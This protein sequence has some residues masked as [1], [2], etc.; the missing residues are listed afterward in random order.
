LPPS[1]EALIPILYEF[2]RFHE[3]VEVSGKS[4]QHFRGET[5]RKMN[6]FAASIKNLADQGV[7]SAI[8]LYGNLIREGKGFAVNNKEAFAWFLKGAV[9]GYSPSMGNVALMLKNG[10]GVSQNTPEAIKWLR[11]CADTGDANAFFNLALIY[12]NGE[13]VPRD[14]PQAVRYWRQ[15]SERG[16]AEAMGN[17]GELLMLGLGGVVHD[18]VEALKWFQTS[19]AK[20]HRK[21][22]LGLAVFYEHGVDWRGIR[23]LKA[24]PAQAARL[25]SAALRQGPDDG[26]I[27]AVGLSRTRAAISARA[28]AAVAS[29]NVVPR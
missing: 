18:P 2:L 21:G 20:H 14:M 13:G 27:A 11:K 12:Q 26:G 16:D 7:P 3:E 6:R 17:L 24:D 28:R 8:Q 25:Y 23:H 22:S 29:S 10:L 19:A 15:A 1:T 5:R 9:L 4:W